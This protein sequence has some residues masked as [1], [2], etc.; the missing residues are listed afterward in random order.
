MTQ[1]YVST[2]VK[3]SFDYVDPEYFRL[4]QLIEKSYVYSFRVVLFEVL[5]ARPTVI[6]NALEKQV[7]LAE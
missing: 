1:T 6:S 2:A 7:S 4:R 3:G 5:C